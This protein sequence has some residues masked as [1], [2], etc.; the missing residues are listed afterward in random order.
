[1]KAVI[2]RVKKASVEIGG[3]TAGSIEIGFLVLLGVA[4][5]DAEAECDA[6]AG[7]VARLRIFEDD[8]GKMNLSLADVGGAVLVISNFTLCAD[9]SHG[10]RPDFFG[11]MRPE[12]A[13]KLYE[14]FMEQLEKSD[15]RVER[16]EFGADMQVSLVNDGP[17]TIIIDSNDLKIKK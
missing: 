8:A 14:R 10:N 2:Q 7:K 16:G 15:L 13:E 4:G 9:C 11:A 3:R 6:L 12:G 17:V 1:M 5:T